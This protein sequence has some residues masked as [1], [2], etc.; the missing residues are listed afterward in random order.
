M[1]KMTK[2]S[3]QDHFKNQI[4]DAEILYSNEST[5]VSFLL[6]C[7][8]A[9]M[10]A[11]SAY[12]DWA[13]EAHQIPVL[14]ESFF[15]KQAPTTEFF[16]K[17][18][19]VFAW[20]PECLPVAEWEGVLVVACLEKPETCTFPAIFVL[21]SYEN[22]ENTWSTFKASQKTGNTDVSDMTALAATIV[23]PKPEEG[24]FFN[25]DGS[26]ALQEADISEE[27]NA[28]ESAAAPEEET[29][30][31]ESSEETEGVPEGLFGDVM[32]TGPS[33]V[34]ALNSFVG[35][36]LESVQPPPNVNIP[37][38]ALDIP[39]PTADIPE[40]VT[41][42]NCAIPE[43]NDSPMHAEMIRKGPRTSR[44]L[45][46]D[47]LPVEDDATLEISPRKPLG[48]PVTQLPDQLPDQLPQAP[49]KM[50]QAAPLNGGAAYVLEKIRKQNQESFEKEVLASFN[51]FKTFFKKS[52]LLAIG[53]K[54]SVVKPLMW[55]GG[56]E[57][58][59]PSSQEFS[60]KIPS[61]FRVVSG[62]QKP[63]HGYVVVNDLN[64]AFFE[65]WNH[66]Q[67]PDHIT[68][69]PLLDND[70]VVGMLMGFGEKASY[71]KNVLQF[72]ENVA[73]NLSKKI[74]KPVAKVA[75]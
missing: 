61:I 14:N 34:V 16:K 75:A 57:I 60:L 22:L 19:S 40:P 9:K 71:N 13:R 3:W 42:I 54:D 29:V 5:E 44:P 36:K 28:A 24:S 50:S 69:V 8:R 11:S 73:T 58:R 15:Q 2:A 20:T 39:E 21:T 12:L 23:V 25:A 48:A 72:T 4:Q 52:M 46:M 18:Q 30:A 70:I 43:N 53:D 74:L 38:P 27:E 64:E 31:K 59:K 66:G 1:K 10:I 33:P 45:A 26:L 65:A 67:I 6:F 7:L 35:I 32:A 51:Q 41:T 17:H 63:Y 55:D 56:F 62:T 47:T 68:I 49:I 37:E